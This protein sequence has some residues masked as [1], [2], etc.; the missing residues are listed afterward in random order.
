MKNPS[1]LAFQ[2]LCWGKH[3]IFHLVFPPRGP[4]G[5]KLKILAPL[6]LTDVPKTRL[7]DPGFWALAFGQWVPNATEYHRAEADLGDRSCVDRLCNIF[8]VNSISAYS[9]YIYTYIHTV[10][11]HISICIYIGSYIYTNGY[12]AHR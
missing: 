5:Q 6:T 4:R 10:H 1:S 9:I 11:L 12:V 2:N 7:C 3:G 8:D